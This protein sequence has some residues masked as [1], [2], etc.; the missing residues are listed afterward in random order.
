MVVERRYLV[1]A[2]GL[3]LLLFALLFVSA[4][5][6][7]KIETPPVIEAVLVGE[8]YEQAQ[9]R[10]REEQRK[11]QEEE[12]QQRLEQERLEQQKLEEQR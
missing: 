6:H 9:E 5:F 4:F 11:R 7:R 8:T 2:A 1:I 12:R 3:H 10:E